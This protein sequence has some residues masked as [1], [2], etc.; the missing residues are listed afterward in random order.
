MHC[1]PLHAATLAQ[2]LAGAAVRYD[3][4]AC[5]V[6][7]G[8]PCC[9]GHLATEQTLAH[10]FVQIGIQLCCL[11][12]KTA[13]GRRDAVLRPASRL[14]L[15]AMGRVSRA[16]HRTCTRPFLMAHDTLTC[17]K[18]AACF[19]NQRASVESTPSARKRTH[20]AKSVLDCSSPVLAF[21]FS[22]ITK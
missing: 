13:Y 17:L 20:Q 11:V 3:P 12:L 2:A 18:L 16:I 8:R 22:F 15:V 7:L 5:C 4:A 6:C 10:C 9:A 1:P 19:V 21:V 14:Q